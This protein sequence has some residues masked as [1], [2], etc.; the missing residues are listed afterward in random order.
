MHIPDGFLS[1]PV[2]LTLDALAAPAVSWV[3][4]RAGRIADGRV[5]R[6][7]PLLGVMGAFVFAAQMVN[8]PLGMG[9][10]GHLLG[11]TLLAVTLGPRAAVLVMS[12]VLILQALVFQDGGILALGANVCNMAIAGVAAGY[13]PVRLWGRTRGAIFAGGVFSV[14]VS[15]SLALGQLLLSG[16][17]MPP[18]MLWIS[19][20]LFLIAGV[21]EGAIT[22]AAAG[23]I[24]RMHPRGLE[25]PRAGVPRAAVAV[26]SASV[27]LLTLGTLAA[28]SL[29]DGLQNLIGHQPAPSL[30][31]SR[32]LAGLA[33]GTLIFGICLAGGRLLARRGA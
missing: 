9:T 19:M 32:L 29:P 5:E 30:W 2:W 23:A 31:L 13:L 6:Q 20:A 25:Q 21:V 33:G 16:V 15:A 3:A 1:P 10:S 26:A 14:L 11:G 18:R 28:S 7:A 12:A 8:F 27:V 17:A 22:V 24:D 4:R